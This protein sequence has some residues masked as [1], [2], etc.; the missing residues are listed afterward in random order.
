MCSRTSLAEPVE[1]LSLF[2]LIKTSAR[3]FDSKVQKDLRSKTPL[4]SEC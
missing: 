1:E 2:F 4:R 3:V